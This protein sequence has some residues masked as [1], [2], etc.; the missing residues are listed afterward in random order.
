MQALLGEVNALASQLRKS[1]AVAGRGDGV[2]A[3]V[4]GILRVLGERGPQTVPGIARARGNSRQSV[5][6]L[7]NRLESQGW[8]EFR[9]NPAHKRS[10][11]V[12]LTERGRVLLAKAAKRE[13]ATLESRLGDL[14][15]RG[16][17]RACALLRRI[18]C[19]LARNELAPGEV[20]SR[21]QGRKR[22][23][24]VVQPARDASEHLPFG[25]TQLAGAAEN[26]A[27]ALRQEAAAI[28]AEEVAAPEPVQS[29]EE[30]FP[31]NLL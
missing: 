1:G 26:R 23:L 17:I 9:S 14:S 18:R 16:L 21:R 10:A 8:V 13:M 20:V 12:C 28:G 2:P 24:A 5:Q 22:A 11:L 30:E 4:Q 25:E 27:P 31:V 6:V 29:E 3:G 7:V 19:A 15:E